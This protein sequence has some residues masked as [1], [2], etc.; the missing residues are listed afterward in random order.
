MA[1]KYWWRKTAERTGPKLCQFI[2]PDVRALNCNLT[3]KYVPD[4]GHLEGLVGSIKDAGFKVVL[5]QGVWDMFHVGHLRYLTEA[6]SRGDFLIVGVDSDKLVK[7]LKGANRP[8]D[9]LEE[10]VEVLAG[11]ACVDILTGRD[12][13]DDLDD[14]VRLVQPDTLVTSKSTG[15][16][17][18]ADRERLKEFCGE[19]IALEAQAATTTT[20]RTLRLMNEGMSDLGQKVTQFIEEQLKGDK[21][22]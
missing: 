14:L 16:M 18:D 8:Y 17:T 21:Q 12:N 4:Y 6:S 11:L 15:S 9:T 7:A 13:P 5:T 2:K 10:R 3:T 20:A 22:G 19:L 1:R